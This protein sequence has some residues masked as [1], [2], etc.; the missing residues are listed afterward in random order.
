MMK[1]LGGNMSSET[2]VKLLSHQP[3]CTAERSLQAPN[4][5]MAYAT[6]IPVPQIQQANSKGYL[7][8]QRS[9]Q[10]KTVLLQLS[11]KAHTLLRYFSGGRIS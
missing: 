4:E 5:A 3:H 11:W 6:R 7:L 1:F 8:T 2:A 10:C 9:G